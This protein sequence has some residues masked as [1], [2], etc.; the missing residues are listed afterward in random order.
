MGVTVQNK[1]TPFYGPRRRD[2]RR[3]KS[4]QVKMNEI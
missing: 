3:R 2:Y 1:V 4:L